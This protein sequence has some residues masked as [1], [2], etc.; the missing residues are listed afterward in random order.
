[1]LWSKLKALV[2]KMPGMRHRQSGM[3]AY[4]DSVIAFP[5]IS[6]NGHEI[7]QEASMDLERR[8]SRNVLRR[9]VELFNEATHRWIPEA[10]SDLLP[11]AS[12]IVAQGV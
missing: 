9:G 1:M 11:V 3:F 5:S 4:L 7:Y 12:N 6:S 8:S 10:S 2:F